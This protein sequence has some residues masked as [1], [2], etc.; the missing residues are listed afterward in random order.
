MFGD[1]ADAMPTGKNI[2]S[3]I[4]ALSVHVYATHSV[5]AFYAHDKIVLRVCS[6]S[7]YL[8]SVCALSALH[9][10]CNWTF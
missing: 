5:L 8:G 3:I 7:T 10:Y 4:V 6:I 9:S 2:G 1:P